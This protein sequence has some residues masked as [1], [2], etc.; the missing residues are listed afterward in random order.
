MRTFFFRKLTIGL[1][2][3]AV[4]ALCLA[5]L[6][7]TRLAAY[8]AGTSITLSKA[9]GPPGTQVTMKGNDFGASEIVTLTFDGAL[10]GTTVT[11]NGGG[12]FTGF[13]VPKRTQPGN[14]TV[15]ATGQSS[16]NSATAP[17][18]VPVP[19]TLSVNTGPPT[20]QVTV[21]GAHFAARETVVVTFDVTTTLGTTTTT[22]AGSFTLVISIPTSAVPGKHAIQATGQSSGRTGSQFFVVRTN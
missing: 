13:T 1:S 11:T 6:G 19:I 5:L 8:A 15:Q 16:G 20:T 22:G 12:F 17:Y 21:T 14:H 18:I 7:L 2:L 9:S 10:I 4:F 3:L